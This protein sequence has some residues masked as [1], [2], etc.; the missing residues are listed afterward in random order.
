M[1]SRTKKYVKTLT[2]GKRG[3]RETTKVE[4]SESG[5]EGRR[6]GEGGGR[7]EAG[8]INEVTPKLWPPLSTKLPTKVPTHR[9]QEILRRHPDRE[10]KTSLE[11]KTQPPRSMG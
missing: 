4:M 2:M 11:R 8:G 10:K 1:R 6:E 7:K 5:R 3:S 9:T